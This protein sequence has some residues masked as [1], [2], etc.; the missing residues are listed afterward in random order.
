MTLMS[1]RVYVAG[2]SSERNERAKPVIAA[3]EAAGYVIT[4]DWTKSVDMH[5]A[6]NEAKTLTK[7]ALAACAIDDVEGVA[8]ADVFV[9]LAPQGPS[10]GAWVELGVALAVGCDIYVSGNV[11]KC[12]FTLIPGCR[13]FDTDAELLAELAP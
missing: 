10:T 12:I 2:A 1:E 3:L 5:G 11:E 8:S 6:N 4:H 7:E 13:H 9:L